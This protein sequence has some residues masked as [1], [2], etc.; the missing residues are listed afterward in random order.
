MV[1]P[2]AQALGLY[3]FFHGQGSNAGTRF[4]QQTKTVRRCPDL[5]RVTTS[6]RVAGDSV[7]ASQLRAGIEDVA[8]ILRSKIRNVYCSRRERS[9]YK[10]KNSQDLRDLAI[11]FARISHA[12]VS[13]STLVRTQSEFIGVYQPELDRRK[14]DLLVR[15]AQLVPPSRFRYITTN[16]N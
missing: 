2:D 3:H 9:Q 8:S 14:G 6:Q 4:R 11:F 1:R 7:I 16:L 5:W 12:Y 15:F 13:H 10:S